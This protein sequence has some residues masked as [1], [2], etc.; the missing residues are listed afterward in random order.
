MAERQNIPENFSTRPDP[1]R[2]V[3]GD[4]IIFFKIWS[5]SLFIWSILA[6][7]DFTF[8]DS[9]A[10]IAVHAN[11]VTIDRSVVCQKF[12]ALH[13][14]RMTASSLLADEVSQVFLLA[15]I[16]SQFLRRFRS[17]QCFSLQFVLL[18]S[19]CFGTDVG[20]LKIK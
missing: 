20:Q 16:F 12:V 15:S 11:A 10:V 19:L 6:R 7:G 1:T 4:I 9:G 13:P 17:L 14:R 18:K 3:I 5:S 2:R 8:N